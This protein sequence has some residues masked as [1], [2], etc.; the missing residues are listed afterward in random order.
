M[1][2]N[3]SIIGSMT[4]IIFFFIILKMHMQSQA[5]WYMPVIL[6]FNRL[7]ARGLRLKDRLGY[8]RVPTCMHACAARV[9]ACVYVCAYVCV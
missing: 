5:W 7:E 4:W 3:H 6:A 2:Y 8:K 9:C 1:G